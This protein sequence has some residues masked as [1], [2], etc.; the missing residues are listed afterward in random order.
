[1]LGLL[2]RVVEGGELFLDVAVRL[3]GLVRRGVALVS[4]QTA[5]LSV[6]AGL[7]VGISS[8]GSEGLE[9]LCGVEGGGGGVEGGGGGGEGRREV[10]RLEVRHVC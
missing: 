6:L 9:H 4:H 1:M 8:G 2:C 3:V 7:V 10:G 5:V